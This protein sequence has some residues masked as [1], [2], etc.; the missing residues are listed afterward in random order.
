MFKLLAE[1][2][3]VQKHED[4]DMILGI[5]TSTKESGEVDRIAMSILS[6]KQRYSV[7]KGGTNAIALLRSSNPD[8]FNNNLILRMSDKL[9]DYNILYRLCDDPSVY[10]WSWDDVQQLIK[11]PPDPVFTIMSP[12]WMNPWAVM[13]LLKLPMS[14]DQWLHGL[15]PRSL[16]A[17][18]DYFTSEDPWCL[19]TGCPQEVQTIFSMLFKKGWIY[20]KGDLWLPSKKHRKNAP[21]FIMWRKH[22]EKF[23]MIRDI[24]PTFSQLLVEQIP[25]KFPKITVLDEMPSPCE[26]TL[27]IGFSKWDFGS[28][29]GPHMCEWDGVEKAIFS[30][31][32]YTRVVFLVRPQMR[33][34]L[35]LPHSIYPT[36][37]LGGAAGFVQRCIEKRLKCDKP[38]INFLILVIS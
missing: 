10:D 32:I 31:K 29:P 16:Q 26:N 2:Y 33:C 13:H 25:Q 38:V 23:G 19:R 18:R 36:T 14:S 28:C 34:Q 17:V 1:S 12:Y 27:F 11:S 21:R 20:K 8:A 3:G 35:E 5:D 6:K 9:D 4:L 30:A 24:S 37:R 7:L 22:S 15:S